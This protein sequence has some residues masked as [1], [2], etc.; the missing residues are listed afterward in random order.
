[1]TTQEYDQQPLELKVKVLRFLTDDVTDLV[2]VR[3]ALQKKVEEIN[4]KI[5]Q[6]QKKTNDLKELATELKAADLKAEEVADELEKWERQREETMVEL[7]RKEL[8]ELTEKIGALKIERNKASRSQAKLT[9]QIAK[10]RKEMREL[11]AEIPVHIHPKRELGRDVFGNQ[12]IV[13]A[14]DPERVYL[15][16]ETMARGTVFTGN[17]G[18]L[19]EF[20][21]ALG[22]EQRAIRDRLAETVELGILEEPRSR[23]FTSKL[24]GK[25][26]F[27]VKQDDDK[28]RDAGEEQEGQAHKIEIEKP[29]EEKE[30]KK[31]KAEKKAAEQGTEQAARNDEEGPREKE[32]KTQPGVTKDTEMAKQEESC[33]PRKSVSWML[34]LSGLDDEEELDSFRRK[35][36]AKIRNYENLENQYESMFEAPGTRPERKAKGGKLLDGFL[37]KYYA[38]LVGRS[39][40]R[41]H[42]VDFLQ[43]L[44]FY[45]EEHYSDYLKLLDSFWLAE[46]DW[47]EQ[48][49]NR[50]NSCSTVDEFKKLLVFLNKSFQMRHFY[51]EVEDQ[52]LGAMRVGTLG[53]GLSEEKN[54]AQSESRAE[55]ETRRRK[56][57]EI[58]DEGGQRI[59][60]GNRVRRAARFEAAARE[61][62]CRIDHRGGLQAKGHRSASG[63]QVGEGDIVRLLHVQ[64]QEALERLR[65]ARQA[66]GQFGVPGLHLRA[67]PVPLHI[68][69]NGEDGEEG[70][71]RKIARR[72]DGPGLP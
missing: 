61:E 7:N 35:L 23:K 31:E 58:A 37:G 63:S 66:S 45:L 38:L 10:S 43:E 27:T 15:L 21:N 26:Y 29:S 65:G 12:L 40:A 28:G 39:I 9:G 54:D 33:K 36:K 42:S 17:F 49:Y 46:E 71:N 57:K 69:Q 56:A 59:D 20:L 24:F 72:R 52:E 62:P 13:F 25:S 41:R 51:D 48:F 53:G 22:R 32:E 44:I 8:G 16:D 30:E 14:F 6:R 55:D 64:A 70:R 47:E 5:T 68:H 11:S 34:E 4:Q 60:D 3:D 2:M 67:E 50:V 1:M 18:V 19:G